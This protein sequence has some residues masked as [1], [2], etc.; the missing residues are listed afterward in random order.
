MPTDQELLDG[1]RSEY[2]IVAETLQPRLDLL[3]ALRSGHRAQRRR[4][5]ALSM[6][7]PAAG[8]GLVVVVSALLMNQSGSGGGVTAADGSPA[9][10]SSVTPDIAP[11]LAGF[12]PL[13]AA[14]TGDECPWLTEWPDG[15]PDASV[16]GVLGPDKCV[17]IAYY[18]RAVEAPADAQPVPVGEYAGAA[19][20]DPATGATR[21]YVGM[22]GGQYV[23]AGWG[24]TVEEL[25]PLAAGGLGSSGLCV[26]TGPCASPAPPEQSYPADTSVEVVPPPASYP[27]ELP[28]GAAPVPSAEVTPP[29]TSAGVAPP[30]SSPAA[31]PAGK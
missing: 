13:L 28:P 8:T 6:A 15:T 17:Q 4:A 12:T 26:D 24:L 18:S 11:Q 14:A 5:R 20:T 19:V 2:R 31:A 7:L 21:L 25:V 3:D 29:A 9:Q 27:A 1:L 22:P 30:E 23:L 10:S 16:D